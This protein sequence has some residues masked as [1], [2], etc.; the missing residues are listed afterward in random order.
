[1]QRASHVIRSPKI[2]DHW[3]EKVLP[4]FSLVIL[5]SSLR[6]GAILAAL[7]GA[8]LAV[9]WG[10]GL[11]FAGSAPGLADVLQPVGLAIAALAA[12]SYAAVTRRRP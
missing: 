12:I 2:S 3:K 10:G 7:T 6:L 1:M 9:Y 11:A 8:F 5:S 4:A